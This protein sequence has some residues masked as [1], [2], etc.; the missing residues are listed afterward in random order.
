MVQLSLH[1]STSVGHEFDSWLKKFHL[2][3]G[4][5]KKSH[6]KAR[7]EDDIVDIIKLDDI[8]F[9]SHLVKQSL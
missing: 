5:A 4:A 8:I 2:P 6:M 9:N 7:V 1:T 3:R